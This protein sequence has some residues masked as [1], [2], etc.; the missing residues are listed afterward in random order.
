MEYTLT[1][2]DNE[3]AVLKREAARA[4]AT[5]QEVVMTVFR[6]GLSP[7]A[8]RQKEQD[9]RAFQDLLEKASPEKKQKA[10]DALNEK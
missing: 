3:D 5:L 6:A 10:L 8:G 7:I 4:A 9:A 1:V 2:D